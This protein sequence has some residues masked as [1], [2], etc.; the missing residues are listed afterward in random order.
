[1]VPIVERASC[2]GLQNDVGSLTFIDRTDALRALQLPI[3]EKLEL[4]EP[5]PALPLDHELKSFIDSIESV[6][7]DAGGLVS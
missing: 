4:A 1:L 6:N 2:G 3:I 5:H 7:L